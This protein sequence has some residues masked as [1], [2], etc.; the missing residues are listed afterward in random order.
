MSSC[1]LLLDE[2]KFMLKT[3]KL[4]AVSHWRSFTRVQGTY[5]LELKCVWTLKM[6]QVILEVQ[7]KKPHL[8]WGRQAFYFYEWFHTNDRFVIFNSDEGHFYFII[9]LF[10]RRLLLN[11]SA[12]ILSFWCHAQV[13]YWH[14]ECF[15]QDLPLARV[16]PAP[17]WSFERKRAE[18]ETRVVLQLNPRCL[19]CFKTSLINTNLHGSTFDIKWQK[20]RKQSSHKCEKVGLSIGLEDCLVI[21]KDWRD[22]FR[23]SEGDSGLHIC[24]FTMRVD[25]PNNTSFII[26]VCVRRS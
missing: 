26:L 13:L 16:Q 23:N 17:R 14:K 1:I 19:G 5:A 18:T 4:K 2:G 8:W 22:T 3:T 7:K 24:I 12:D 21:H 20:K 15:L 9:D 10:L 6:L 25:N 11:I